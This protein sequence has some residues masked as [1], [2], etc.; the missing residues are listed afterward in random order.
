MTR[1]PRLRAE[2]YL[3]A[4]RNMRAS[5]LLHRPR[6][7]LP[8]AWL[9][10]GR[11]RPGAWRSAAAGLGVDP[12]PQSGP[13]PAPAESGTFSAVGSRRAFPAQ[14]FWTDER[15]GLLFLFHLHGF[16]DLARYAAGTRTAAGDAFWAAVLGDWL[17]ECGEPSRPGWHP[18][19]TS[20]R[21]I[22]WCAA[23]SAGGWPAELAEAMTRSLARQLRLLRRS[24][25]HDIGG[26]HVLRNAAALIVGGVCVGDPA[27]ERRGLRVLERA[28]ARQV[29]GDGGHEERSPAYHRAVL[30]DLRDVE[31]VLA[32]AGRP[33]PPWLGATALRMEGWLRA[34]AGPDGALPLLNDAWEGPGRAPLEDA[35]T[36]LAD[37]GYVVLRA[38]GDHAVLDVAP[39][40]PPHLPPHAHA[41]ALSFV[42]WVDG[43]PLVIDPGTFAYAGPERGRFRGT[44]AHA[45]VE[46]DGHDQCDLWGPFRAAH[47]PE[48]TRL[49]TEPHGDAMVV[50]AEHDGYARLPDPVRHRR[51]FCWLPGDGLVIV[52]RLLCEAVH[53]AVARLPL[54]REDGPL[55]IATLGEGPP[56]DL[57][58]GVHSPYLGVQRPAPVLTRRLRPA[59]GAP[60]GW[61]LLRPGAEARLEGG[62]LHVDR[63]GGGRLSLDVR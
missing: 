6:R 41:D 2:R 35:V 27:A 56:A 22:A 23:L 51:T 17:R 61:A 8:P 57:E 30:A 36:D 37:S 42:L 5:Q 28:L 13:Q 58:A 39:L 34:L 62:R 29:L 49:A 10:A 31:A 3:D 21:A 12:A 44:A 38:G 26:N 53:D 18:F 4:A 40:A 63:R 32:T 16:G 59:P 15:D 9:A 11:S 43:A 14:G 47:M 48:V 52:D 55:E 24:V 33:A 25:E 45:T 1:P 46:V 20:G 54:A 19:P 50:A 60:F 7:L